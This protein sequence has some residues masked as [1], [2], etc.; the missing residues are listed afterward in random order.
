MEMVKYKF[1]FNSERVV[2][3]STRVEYTDRIDVYI[4]KMARS[5]CM[6]PAI[7]VHIIFPNSSPF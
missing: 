1:P 2:V 4:P 5:V 3:G 7:P 6:I